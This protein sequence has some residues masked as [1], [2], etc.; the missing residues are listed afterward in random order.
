MNSNI[1][2][3]AAMISVALHVAKSMIKESE[4]KGISETGAI[5]RNALAHLSTT[6]GVEAKIATTLL[7]TI[8]KCIMELSNSELEKQT[9]IRIIL[10]AKEDFK[11]NPN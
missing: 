1:E 8:F 5:T 11:I 6:L 9:G 10:C 3:H 2:K 7:V 4:T